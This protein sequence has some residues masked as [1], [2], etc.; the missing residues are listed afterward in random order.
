LSQ[1]GKGLSRQEII[2]QC[3][4]TTGG[5]TSRILKELE[6]SGFIAVYIPFG[7]TA[8]DSLY[9]LHDEYSLFYLKFIEGAKATRAGTWLRQADTPAY[10]SWGGFAFEAVCHKHALQIKKALG[11]EGVLTEESVWRYKP[12]KGNAGQ[13]AQIDLLIDRRDHCINICEMKFATDEYA[14]DKKYAAELDKKVNVFRRETGSR[15]T[16]F[17]TMVTTYGVSRNEYYTGRVL[18]EVLMKDLFV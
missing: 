9:K 17:L 2:Q 16:L 6:E 11:I 10:T 14:I 8:N 13:G 15:K 7:K 12:A 5:T 1:K 18:G 3:G 4:F